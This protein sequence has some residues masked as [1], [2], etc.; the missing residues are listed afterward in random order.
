MDIGIIL[1]IIGLS[2]LTIFFIVYG[3]LTRKTVHYWQ[4]IRDDMMV[5]E[6]YFNYIPKVGDVVYYYIIGDFGEFTNFL[7]E[8]KVTKIVT[9]LNGKESYIKVYTEKLNQ[10]Y[11]SQIP[12]G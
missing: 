9:V 6:G 11:V 5:A 4:V 12:H 2:G 10:M 7:E 3:I 8:G 1:G